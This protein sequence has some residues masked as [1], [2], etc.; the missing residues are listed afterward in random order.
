MTPLPELDRIKFV[1]AAAAQL[2]IEERYHFARAQFPDDE[3]SFSEVASLLDVHSTSS[4]FLLLPLPEL[5]GAKDRP[6]PEPLPPQLLVNGRYRIQSLLARSGFSSVYLAHDETVAGKPVVVKLLDRILSS[7]DGHDD[8]YQA[9]LFALGRLSHPHVAALSDAGQL[10]DGTPFLVMGYVP[11]ETLR[12]RLQSGPLSLLEVRA[13]VKAVGQALAAAHRM[14]IWHLDVKPENIILSDLGT[15]EE[16]VTLIDFGIAQLTGLPPR[17]AGTRQYM[18]PEQE[19]MPSAQSD[20]Y[21]LAVVASEMLAGRPAPAGMEA[22][23]ARARK[24]SPAERHSRMGEFL[25]AALT[26]SPFGERWLIPAGILVLAAAFVLWLALGTQ[27]PVDL[28]AAPLV[29]SPG[30][31][32]RPAF[33]GDGQSVFYASGSEGRYDIYRQSLAGGAAQPVVTHPASDD[34][35]TPSPDGK[36]LAFYRSWPGAFAVMLLPLDGSGPEVELCREADLGSLAWHPNARYLIISTGATDLDGSRLD[37]YDL[38]TRTSRVL[39]PNLPHTRGDRQPTVSSDGRAL[40][41][42]RR[43]TQESADLFVLALDDV[44]RPQGEPRRV[45]SQYERIENVQWSPDGRDLI[46]STGPLGHA[47]IKRVSAS[48]GA[49]QVIPG[50]DRSIEKITVHSGTGRL[51]YSVHLSDSNVWALPLRTGQPPAPLLASTY[52]DEEPRWSPD[53]RMIAFSS[54]RS[55]SEQIWVADADGRN[56]RQITDTPAPD[57]MGVVWSRDSRHL[58]ISIR[59]KGDGERVYLAAAKG[60]P[61][62]TRILSDAKVTDVSRDGR[63]LYV[64]RNT[65]APK[66]LWKTP[67]PSADHF[68]TVSDAPAEFARE[69]VDGQTVYFTH[70][71]EGE[72]LWQVSSSGGVPV[73][74][75]DRLYRRNLFVPSS[76][77]VYYVAGSATE[78]WP[79][80]L[81]RRHSG[82]TTRVHTFGRE[83]FWGMDLLAD[84]TRLA[85]SQFDVANSDIMLVKAFR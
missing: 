30:F 35:P 41:F 1:L 45:T 28:L 5:L 3:A 24:A 42:V 69:S 67:Y 29:A 72:G 37:L 7:P 12:S 78:N 56:P 11:G 34:Y 73:R 58:V 51:A 14:G 80:L 44:A 32:Y 8:A 74:V 61:R 19:S 62:L 39:V 63:W 17:R 52:D 18:A 75:A 46:Y 83:V 13:V 64:I 47:I 20:I 23:I 31:D 77:G 16:R 4:D 2:P 22:A 70:R 25:A 50:L 84:E 10:P 76:D 21:A 49:P 65:T 15:P 71:Q 55:G 82:L 33:S 6:W 81:L 26:E 27:T 59:K 9:E 53:G 43:W 36:Y 54:G 57:A 79:S 68:V 48:G 60:D 66:R 85:Y 38:R 40:A